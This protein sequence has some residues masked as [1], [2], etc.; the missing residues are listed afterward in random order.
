MICKIC[1]FEAEG[2]IFSNHIKKE[3]GL[4]SKEYT[5]KYIYNNNIGCSNCGEETRYVAFKFKKYCKNCSKLAMKEG[6]SKGGKHSAWNKGKTKND[7]SRIASNSGKDNPFWGKKHKTETKNRISMTKRLGSVDVLNRVMERNEEFEILTPIEEYF[8][9][10]RQY[11]EFKCKKCEFVCKKTLQA[12]ERGSLCP[13]CYPMS[14]SKAELEVYE[15]VKS[16]TEYNVVSG[17]RSLIG[18]KE[19]DITVTSDTVR[20]GIEF[21]G[22]YWHSEVVDN[23]TKEDLLNKTNLCKEKDYKLMHIFS[24][25]WEFKKDICKSMIRNRI[26]LSK[27]IYARKCLVKEIDKKSFDNFMNLS[28]IDGKVNSSI[29]LG[30]FYNDEL[31]SAIGFRKPRQKKWS[32]YIEI[33]RFATKLDH[34]VVGGLSKLLSYCKKN[35]DMQ[36]IMTYSDRRFGW[37]SGYEKVGFKKIGNSGIDYW[38]TDGINRYDRFTIKTDDTMTEKEKAADMGLYKVWGCGSFIWTFNAVL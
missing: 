24:D 1:G 6:G 20:L 36:K 37:G 28:H 31:V 13:K 27:K 35:Y 2:K 38:Y 32:E 23:T 12:F 22:L 4:S 21:N 18:P 33:S 34:V 16:I 9:R 29:R 17:N 10:Q 11:L 15:F 7:D 5:A 26:G 30:L 19:I 3:H 25:E 14:K 8:S